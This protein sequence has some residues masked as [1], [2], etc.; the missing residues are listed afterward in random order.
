MYVIS[1]YIVC[2]YTKVIQRT[3][4]VISN[5]HN[6]S[7]F[8]YLFFEKNPPLIWAYVVQTH[9]QGS[10]IHAHTHTHKHIY[11]KNINDKKIRMGGWHWY[12]I[13]QWT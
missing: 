1:I 7:K 2:S 12:F 3:E 6:P 13:S 5:C 4:N 9:V 11:G 10:N 8:T